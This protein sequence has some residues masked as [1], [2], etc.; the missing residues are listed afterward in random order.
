MTDE[1]RLSRLIAITAMTALAVAVG[2]CAAKTKTAS[3]SAAPTKAGPTETPTEAAPNRHE[4]AHAQIDSLMSQI[5]SWEGPTM[6]V[7]GAGSMCTAPVP[8]TTRCQDVCKLKTSICGNA[9]KIC[10]IADGIP[11]DT[12]ARQKCAEANGACERSTKRCCGCVDQESNARF[13]SQ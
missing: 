9:A 4:G 11:D 7:D 8:K 10:R 2:S 13:D 1:R 3:K 6:S 5:K 12:W